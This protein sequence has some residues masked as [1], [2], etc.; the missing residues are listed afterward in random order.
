M[1]TLSIDMNPLHPGAIFYQLRLYYD[2]LKLQDCPVTVQVLT[3]ELAR[4]LGEDHPPRKTLYYQVYCW[5]LQENIVQRHVT[6]MAQ[7]TSYKQ[8][9]ID[10]FVTYM[11]NQAAAGQH[12]ASCIVKIDEMNII[13]V[14]QEVLHWQAL[15]AAW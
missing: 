7:N 2:K 5:L 11:N 8:S 13:L 3:L 6:Q 10:D 14:L 9:V 1:K 15:E 4:M 12:N